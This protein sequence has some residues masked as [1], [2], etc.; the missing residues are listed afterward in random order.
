MTR[1]MLYVP[2]LWLVSLLL[3]LEQ[4][5]YGLFGCAFRDWQT[6]T[7]KHGCSEGHRWDLYQDEGV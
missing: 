7:C 5:S 6:E 3:S 2:V 1:A 4:A